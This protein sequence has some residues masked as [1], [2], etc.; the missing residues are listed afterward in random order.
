LLFD[1]LGKRPRSLPCIGRTEKWPFSE[2]FKWEPFPGEN[3]A[4]AFSSNRLSSLL[5]IG[6]M[7]SFLM[8]LFKRKHETCSGSGVRRSWLDTLP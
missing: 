5:V 8:T 3:V 4:P 1:R 2:T 7:Q 6:S